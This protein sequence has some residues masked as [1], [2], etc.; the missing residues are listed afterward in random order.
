LGFTCSI[1]GEYHAEELRDIRLGLP[2]EIYALGA[3]ERAA[4]AWLADDF[5]VL[6]D[7]S[8]Y[9]RGLLEVPIP[10]VGDRFA[11][12]AWVEVAPLRFKKLM[13]RWSDPRQ[14]K[15]VTCFL[16]NELPP[17]RQ[18][19]SLEATLRPV[20]VNEL[21]TIELSEADHELVREQRDGISVDRSRELAAV[22]A[23]SM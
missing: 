16:A 3:E 22:V 2:D 21:P 6:D 11:Y 7:E 10:E 17:Y 9:V 1:C 5:A 12:G 23:H 14:F 13:K 8:F 4:R 19:V 18:T 20:S 15:P